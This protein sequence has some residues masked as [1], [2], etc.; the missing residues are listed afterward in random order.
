MTGYNITDDEPAGPY[1]HLW[2]DMPRQSLDWMDDA[3]CAT[4]PL[5]AGRDPFDLAGIPNKPRKAMQ[6]CSWCPVMRECA[7][8][9]LAARDHGVVRAG[10][11]LPSHSDDIKQ[12]PAA[13]ERLK[14]IAGI[15][16]EVAA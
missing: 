10:T 15:Q 2:P 12:L 8:A 11:W 4:T 16:Q 6:A 9:T 5:P 13:I 7:T 14:R 1:A 3:K